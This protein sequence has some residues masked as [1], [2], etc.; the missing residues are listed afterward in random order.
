V[1]AVL[2]ALA[3]AAGFVYYRRRASAAHK[4]GDP[5]QKSLLGADELEMGSLGP[6]IP[7]MSEPTVAD[8]TPPLDPNALHTKLVTLPVEAVLSTAIL[9]PVGSPE[10]DPDESFPIN[11]SA[12]ALCAWQWAARRD[13]NGSTLSGEQHATKVQ[14][15][16]LMAAT[17]NFGDSHKIGVGGSCVV[18]KTQLYGL[19]CA[20]KLLS[21]DA[22]AW[23]E[24]QFTAEIDVLTRVK[25]ENICQLYACSTDGP[26]RCLVLELMDFSLENR[27]C[28][29]PPLG[30]EQRTYILVCVC[31]GLVH[32]HSQS[33]P[34]IHR[35]VKSDNG[36]CSLLF[37]TTALQSGVHT[38]SSF[39][40]ICSPLSFKL[41]TVHAH[42]TTFWL[43]DQ[44]PRPQITGEDRRL[45]D[46]TN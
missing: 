21:Q 29:D 22:S 33:P 16:D 4:K 46:C 8:T 26:N 42:S 24:R 28:T 31:R 14:Y 11:D 23:E 45:R 5:L 37:L 41:G 34:L 9:S 7:H 43:H 20:I 15:T 19:P 39:S 6:N 10:F 44:L 13:M 38:V 30:W 35:D 32:L 18:Y 27:V 1:I 25:H 36:N 3:C 17:H 2:A 12:R 40:C